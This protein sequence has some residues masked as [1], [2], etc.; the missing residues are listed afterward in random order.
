LFRFPSPVDDI[1]IAVDPLTRVHAVADVN[2]VVAK[3]ASS[4]TPSL[5]T[6]V[7]RA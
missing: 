4:V 3:T 6:T 5:Y 2:G 1:E 7:T